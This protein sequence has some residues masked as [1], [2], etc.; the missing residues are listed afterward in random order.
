MTVHYTEADADT[1]RSFM[2]KRKRRKERDLA[3]RLSEARR[4]FKAI[5]VEIARRYNPQRIYQWGSLIDGGHFTELSDIDIAVEG[6]G[7]PQTFFELLGTAEKIT[8]FDLDIVQME[9]LHPAYA[10][11]IRRRG[12]IV[13]ERGSGA[14]N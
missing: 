2:R 7:D 10:D 14:G 8:R 1:I 9:H 5:V 12:R 6:I 3:L 13:Y 11:G 4:D